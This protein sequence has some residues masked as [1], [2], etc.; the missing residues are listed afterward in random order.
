MKRGPMTALA[1]TMATGLFA[2]GTGLLSAGT[3]VDINP[4]HLAGWAFMLTSATSVGE[5]VDGPDT[6]PLGM[7]SLRLAT[8]GHGD[9]SAQLRNPLFDGTGLADLTA[10]TYTTFAAKWAGQSLPYIVLNV[11]LNGDGMFDLDVDDLLFFEP[12]YQAPATGN[13][14]LPDQGPAL[15]STWQRWNALAGGW[16]SLHGIAAATPG[17]GVKSL[18]DYVVAQPGATI[19]NNRFGAGGV[20]LV[21]GFGEVQDEFDGYVDV[22]TIGVHGDEIAYNFGAGPTSITVEIDIT[23]SD[24]PNAVNSKDPGVV[25][26]AILSTPD[27]SATQGIDA[28][29]LTFGRSGDEQSLDACLSSPVDVNNDG[30]LDLVCTFDIARTAFQCDDTEGFLQGQLSDGRFIQGADAV[31]AEPCS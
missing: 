12:A 17:A 24:Y 30:L 23:P 8:G 31:M 19:V 21:V 28:P 18:Q 1:V 14:S 22:L 5:V 6:P 27:F 7:G 16:W 10:L 11:D 4:R 26:V 15:L 2:L 29:S 13:P 3:T 9:L 20:R 25:S